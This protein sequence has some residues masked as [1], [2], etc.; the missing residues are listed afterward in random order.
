MKPLSS[1]GLTEIIDWF[2]KEE[3]KKEGDA[4]VR[5]RALE[6]GSGSFSGTHGQN[7]L[8]FAQDRADFAFASDCV[9]HFMSEPTPA[10]WQALKRI[11][12]SLIGARRIVQ[13]FK[14]CE[15]SSH[16]ESYGYSD[17]A[18]DKVSRRCDMRHVATVSNHIQNKKAQ[19]KTSAQCFF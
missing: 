16:I 5:E 6:R 13:T 19:V 11:G 9:S 15:V 12:R 10:A 3:D 17:W 14:W 18:G 2:K 4:E 8:F 1:P 7:R